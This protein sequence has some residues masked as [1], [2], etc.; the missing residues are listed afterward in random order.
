MT[1]RAIVRIFP[2]NEIRGMGAQGSWPRYCKKDEVRSRLVNFQKLLQGFHRGNDFPGR[3]PRSYNAEQGFLS[4]CLLFLISQHPAF[5]APFAG[6]GGF[7]AMPAAKPG[8]AGGPTPA[9]S[10][11]R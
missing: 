5:P 1:P 11:A 3:L 6:C 9:S 8:C 7:S 10:N 4:E 2:I